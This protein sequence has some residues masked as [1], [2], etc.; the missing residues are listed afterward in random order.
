MYMLIYTHNTDKALECCSF[1]FHLGLVK[2]YAYIDVRHNS[3]KRPSYFVH[4][5][6][7]ARLRL[8][9]HHG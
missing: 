4:L 5:T 3:L 7:E 1:C 8:C 2:S 6:P 9:I